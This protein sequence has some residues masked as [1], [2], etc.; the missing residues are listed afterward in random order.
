MAKEYI[1]KHSELKALTIDGLEY[2]ASITHYGTCSTAATTTAKIVALPGFKLV[3]GARVE[4]RFTVANTAAN[5]TL[6]VNNTGAKAIHYNNAAVAASVLAANSTFLMI[7]DGTYWQIVGN[8]YTHPTTAGN[9]HIPTG[10]SAGQIL[11][12]SA[13]GTAKWGKAVTVIQGTQSSGSATIAYQT[14]Y[15]K[16][17]LECWRQSSIASLSGVVIGVY[18]SVVLSV[19]ATMTAISSTYLYSG[20][21]AST[22]YS[23]STSGTISITGQGCDY[24]ATFFN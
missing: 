5:P 15:T 17:L 11:E 9:K 2:D 12:Y 3:T 7:Y 14:G 16:V 20:S 10:G 1:V 4:V 24:R 18:G 22:S 21:N 23:V 13:A 19:A 6:N 8:I